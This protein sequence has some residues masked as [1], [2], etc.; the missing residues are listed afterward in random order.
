MARLQRNR[1]KQGGHCAEMAAWDSPLVYAGNIYVGIS[2][3]CDK[4][5]VRG[6]LEEFSQATGAAENT[7]WSTPAGTVGASIWSSPAA[8]G[9]SVFVTTGN[10]ASS[11]SDGFSIVKLSA[12]LSKLDIWTVPAAECDADSDFGGSPGIWSANIGGVS[13]KMVGACNKNGISTPSG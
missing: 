12:S 10:G 7:Y 3:Q 4:P 9:T 2:S 6:G 11:S 13:T 8:S 1:R 5:L